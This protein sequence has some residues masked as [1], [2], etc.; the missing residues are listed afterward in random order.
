MALKVPRILLKKLCHAKKD[1]REG[2]F[3]EGIN[4]HLEENSNFI[5][6]RI[7]ICFLKFHKIMKDLEIDTLLIPGLTNPPVKH[8]ETTNSTLQAFYTFICNVF[9]LPAG[10][11]PIT[12]VREDE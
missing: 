3:L 6:D 8:F 2:Y 5:H 11:I 1:E 9:N 4:L 7:K 12:H 10:A